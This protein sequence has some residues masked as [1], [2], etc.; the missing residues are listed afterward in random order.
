[1]PI[2]QHIPFFSIF[3]PL[4]TAVMIPLVKK[5]KIVKRMTFAAMLVVVI[6]SAILVN[7]LQGSS[8]GHFTYM[9]GHYPAPWGNELKSSIMEAALALIFGIV[10]ILSIAG[11]LNG[12]KSD[13]K[14]ENKYSYYIMMN[15]I[16]SSLL[17]LVYT[18]DMFTAY[19]FLEINTIAACSIVV[20]KENG[21]TIRATIKYFIMSAL[22]SGLYLFAVST[23]YG[24]TGHLLMES[25]NVAIREIAIT[26]QYYFP[27]SVSL[28]LII[29]AIAVKSALFPFHTWLPD[30]YGSATSS[31]SA[32][33]SGLVSKGY[34][35][36]LIKIIYRVFGIEVV[37]NLKVLPVILV[38]G[39]LGMMM[40]SILAL[41]QK[42]LKKMIA[43]SSIAQIGYIFMGIGLG[44]KAALNAAVFHMI[45]HAITKAA[46]FLTAG[47]VIH[48][49]N[50]KKIAKMKGIG[51]LMPITMA[52]FTI[53][54]LSMIGI[55]P[56]IG[57]NSKWNFAQSIMSS[58]YIW[59][60][61]LLSISSLLNALYYLPII[62][63]AFFSIEGIGNGKKSKKLEGPI[64]ELLPVI[65]LGVLIIAIGVYSSPVYNV[66]STGLNN[67]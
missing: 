1:M 21:D 62:V 11:G 27:L 42:D 54:G 55:P 2:Q 13:I 41:L 18:N 50:N 15:L 3:I 58:D 49:T 46:L 63:R 29:V 30:T 25:M 22:G 8:V 7:Y 67:L 61:I 39:L 6:L 65:I 35:I 53:G 12:I 32:V 36:L 28:V 59:T 10:M 40:G 38:L 26:G 47:S 31:S 57:F 9:V 56:S 64:L 48:E 60:I 51:V 5:E 43:Y 14:D 19:V 33:L 45:T 34:I 52:V 24:I 66:I 23:L 37:R 17:A 16:I 20:A 44:T 4:I